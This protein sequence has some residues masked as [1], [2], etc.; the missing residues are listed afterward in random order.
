M[1]AAGRGR[2]LAVCGFLLGGAVGIVSS[3]QTWLTVLRQDG[4]EPILVAG[5]DALALLAPLSLAVLALG[6]ALTI[7]G[8]A[9]RY[10][11]GALGLAASV[12]LLWW[13]ADLLLRMPTAAV[14]PAV[15][16]ATGLAGEDAVRAVVAE[17]VP[18][19]WPWL[20]LVGWA[21]L[22]AASVL[23]LATARRWRSGGRR[24]RTDH[25]GDA[26]AGPVDAID[27]WD[28][29]SRGTDPTR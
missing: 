15:T 24:F 20:A 16:E 8:R 29:L 23:T 22:C 7:V 13:T 10:V 14:A 19:A 17:I 12:L 26:D 21:V 18:T 2:L 11:F 27:S 25:V 9:L 3:T 5:A 1:S 4:G 28:D 6:A